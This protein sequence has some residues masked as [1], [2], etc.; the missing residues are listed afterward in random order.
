M[1]ITQ[2]RPVKFSSWVCV[3][4]FQRV[5][6]FLS[7]GFWCFFLG[8][9]LSKLKQG[10]EREKAQIVVLDETTNVLSTLNEKRFVTVI[11]TVRKP[12]T[13]VR[14]TSACARYPV[15]ACCVLLSYM[16]QNLRMCSKMFSRF[17]LE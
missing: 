2:K 4:C 10:A 17:N 13:V 3:F 5:T 12:G 16:R 11:H 6:E 7:V 14:T 9:F 15:S 8:H 1:G